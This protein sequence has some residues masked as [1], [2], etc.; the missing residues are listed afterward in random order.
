MIRYTREKPNAM[1]ALQKLHAPRRDRSTRTRNTT[2]QPRQVPSLPPRLAGTPLNIGSAQA[3]STRAGRSRE[4]PA[5]RIAEE[6]LRFSLRIGTRPDFASTAEKT[7]S[8][9]P[10]RRSSGT[11]TGVSLRVPPR[12]AAQLVAARSELER[13]PNEDW[14]NAWRT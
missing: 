12:R 6:A 10:A 8:L 3:A 11:K 13:P 2:V 14:P 9:L 4:T 5:S 7:S 1:P